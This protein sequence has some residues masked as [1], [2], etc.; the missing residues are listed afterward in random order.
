MNRRTFIKNTGLTSIAFTAFPLYSIQN[1]MISYDELIGK[2]N[3]RLYGNSYKLR[4][5]AYDSFLKMKAEAL[6]ENINIQIVSSYRNFAH[7]N[8]IWTRKY[9]LFTEQGLIPEMAIKKIIEYSTIPGTSRHH[10]GTDIDVIDGNTKHPKN[11]LREEHF[12]GNGPFCKLKEWMDKFSESYGFYIVY[13]NS[14]NRKGFKY[15]PWHY[16]YKPLSKKYLQEYKK[17]ELSEMIKNEDLIG[18]EYFSEKF[19]EDYMNNNILDINQELK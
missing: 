1:K 8:K 14:Y 4:K 9:K 13:N 7:Q 5:E 3:P 15:E 19:I 16:S 11:A 18:K 6:K 10:W 2:G 12:H 17:I